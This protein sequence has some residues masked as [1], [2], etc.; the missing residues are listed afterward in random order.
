M[1]SGEVHIHGS[2]WSTGTHRLA[3]NGY[4]DENVTFLMKERKR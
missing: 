4:I 1:Q 2:S 3:Y